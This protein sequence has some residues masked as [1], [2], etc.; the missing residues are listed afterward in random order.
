MQKKGIGLLSDVH[1][2]SDLSLINSVP[3]GGV[4]S[5]SNLFNA[6]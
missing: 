3:P 4:N 5:K 2:K 6:L 1:Y